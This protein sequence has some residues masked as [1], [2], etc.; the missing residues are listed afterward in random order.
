M[1]V[2]KLQSKR[3]IV[4][5]IDALSI[6]GS[7]GTLMKIKEPRHARLGLE[8]EPRMLNAFFH[9][10]GNSRILVMPSGLCPWYTLML[11]SSEAAEALLAA[12]EYHY[13]GAFR[14][15]TS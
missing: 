14:V 6:I 10:S 13:P 8:L 2:I 12:W 7:T 5:S 11:K 9:E 4:L 15:S 1:H 3:S